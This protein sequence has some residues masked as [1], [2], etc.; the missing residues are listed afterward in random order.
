MPRLPTELYRSIFQQLSSRK[1]IYILLFVSHFVMDEAEYALYRNIIVDPSLDRRMQLFQRIIH[2]KRLANLV[3]SFTI[4]YL[5]YPTPEYWRELNRT[6]CRLEKL[7][8][9]SLLS[10][11][12]ANSPSFC[13]LSG[14]S[15]R[16]RFLTVHD[17]QHHDYEALQLQTELHELNI[18]HMSFLPPLDG[19]SQLS[20]LSCRPDEVS[21][22]PAAWITVN[23][24]QWTRTG[25]AAIRPNGFASFNQVK[26][27]ACC[28]IGRPGWGFY[29]RSSSCFHP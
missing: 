8:T 16:L 13:L 1:D 19:F 28:S 23:R 3:R 27:S 2:S 4:T 20:I 6:L 7:T 24:L 5:S 29:F 11:T 10:T 9:L 14:C 26:S 21:Q 25:P 12:D 17:I 15:F 18:E 22:F